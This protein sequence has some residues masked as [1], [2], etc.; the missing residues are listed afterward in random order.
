MPAAS[1]VIAGALEA[2]SSL[3]AVSESQDA[4]LGVLEEG[5]SNFASPPRGLPSA[6]TRIDTPSRNAFWDSTQRRR[7]EALT[8]PPETPWAAQLAFVTKHLEPGEAPPQVL[9]RLM[10]E[11]KLLPESDW[12]AHLAAEG[13]VYRSGQILSPFR[14]G[15]MIIGIRAPPSQLKRRMIP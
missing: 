3:S 15:P 4:L 12:P 14:T 10:G 9:E 2:S 13:G 5:L 7:K 1:V 8:K 6:S 11:L